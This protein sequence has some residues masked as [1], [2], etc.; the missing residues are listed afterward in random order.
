MNL[1]IPSSCISTTDQLPGY[2]VTQSL[3]VSEG[4]AITNWTGF[5]PD[6]QRNAL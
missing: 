3:G 6:A 4:V 5:L 2:R 1:P